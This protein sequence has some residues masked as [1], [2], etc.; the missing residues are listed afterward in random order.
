M[1]NENS[2]DTV[3]VCLPELQEAEALANDLRRILVRSEK[4][5]IQGEAR[6]TMER[7]EHWIESYRRGLSAARKLSENGKDML[8]Q[9]RSKLQLSLEELLRLEDE[10]GNAPTQQHVEQCDELTHAIRRIDQLMPIVEQSFQVQEA[11]ASS[12]SPTKAA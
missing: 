3:M 4:A 2:C 9:T 8:Q 6:E 1:T 5:L 7:L 11:G 12:T 10:G